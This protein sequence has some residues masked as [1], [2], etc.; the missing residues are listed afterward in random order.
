MPVTEIF[1]VST[2]DNKVRKTTETGREYFVSG[3]KKEGQAKYLIEV[4]GYGHEKLANEVRDMVD[5]GG[6]D[7]KLFRIRVETR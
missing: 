7:Q 6:M 5:K 1:Y 2:K 3:G 4:F